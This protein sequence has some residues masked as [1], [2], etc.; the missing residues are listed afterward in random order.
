MVEIYKIEN[1]AKLSHNSIHYLLAIHQS[2]RGQ[3]YARA[4]DISK[5]LG[6]T[7]GSVSITLH[8][9]A[10]KKYI[11]EDDNKF[12]TLT[13]TGSELVNAVLSR[14]RIF[15]I[16]F[17]DV[18]GLPESLA[19]ADG[20]KI[21]HLISLETSEKLYTFI[22]YYLSDGKKAVAFREG[23]SKFKLECAQEKEC[24]ICETSCVFS[25]KNNSEKE[26]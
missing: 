17:Q 23:F 19:E 11:S 5:Q 1:N 3:G 10:E 18:L 8:K 6:L 7:R 4:I 2:I 26:N 14:R 12:Y 16:F 20:C 24:P 15:E 22:G 21:E 13:R 9:L 25:G